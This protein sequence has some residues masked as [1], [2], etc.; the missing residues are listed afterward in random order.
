M[1]KIF[2]LT[3]FIL[4]PEEIQFTNGDVTLSGV[5][6]LP[7]GNGKVPLVIFVHGSGRRTRDDY[8][9]VATELVK[10]GYAV[11]RYDKRGAGKS[12]GD[13]M[14]VGTHNSN[15]RIPL[16]ASDA[17]AAIKSLKSHSRIDRK[18]VI[19]IGGSQAGRIIPVIAGITDVAATVCISGP[20]VSV[21]EEIY[22]SDLAEHGSESQDAADK[23]LNDFR[24]TRG[25]DNTSY[26]RK[27]KKPS[28]WIFGSKD[29][30]IPVK[31]CIARLEK[32]KKEE[33]L[34]VDMKIYANADHGIVNT[35]TRKMENYVPEIITWLR[36]VVPQ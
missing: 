31:E 8:Q 7:T 5:L 18:K 30:S 36:R 27:M 20:T 13:F 24:G 35:S 15:E 4:G 17:V 22:Y 25:F 26:V 9:P 11:F 6:E 21:G 12:S 33:K 3:W 29:V 23:L 19:V 28:F 10:A 32:I 1:L 34:P 14:E 2:A 16:L